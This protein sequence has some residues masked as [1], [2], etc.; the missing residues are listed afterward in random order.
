[1][2]L[3]SL[4]E[5]NAICFIWLYFP[6][7]LLLQENIWQLLPKTRGLISLGFSAF[8]LKRQT[9]S[10]QAPLFSG[11]GGC[12]TLVQDLIPDCSGRDHADI[13]D[14]PCPSFQSNPELPDSTERS[15]HTCSSALSFGSGLHR[16]LYCNA[17]YG[18]LNIL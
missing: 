16:L 11:R 10:T 2:S 8:W 13:R 3:E 1:M 15:A 14:G 18:V 9:K 12:I 6:C 7:K 5:A 17:C 4:L